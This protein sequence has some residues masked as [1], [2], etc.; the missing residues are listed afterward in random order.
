[1]LPLWTVVS[2]KAMHGTSLDY[3]RL[4][5]GFGVVVEA[6]HT[7]VCVVAVAQGL[8]ESLHMLA[9]VFSALHIIETAAYLL[10]TTCFRDSFVEDTGKQIGLLW[11]DK[12]D[13]EAR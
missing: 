6:V 8:G 9:F 1:M 2:W 3:W 11:D 13:P 12:D 7:G 10:V 4:I 5:C